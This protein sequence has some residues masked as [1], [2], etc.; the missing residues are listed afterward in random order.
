[1]N[2]PRS[3]VFDCNVYLQVMLS[4]HGAS[5][6]CWQKVLDGEVVLHAAPFVLAEIRRLP[7]HKSLRRFCS[8]TE[9]RVERFLEA[10]FDTAT[11]VADPPQVLTF[12]RDP[13]DAAYINLAIAV[14][15]EFIV[16][17]DKD[18]LDLMSDAGPDGTALRR[19]CPNLRIVTP[20]QLLRTLGSES[21]D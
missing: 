16:T 2:D 19:L 7:S 10:L 4:G 12:Q 3:A 17:N 8:F 21:S 9:E 20:A 14:G 11:L 1:M 5:C 18:L 13:D 15:A 6:A